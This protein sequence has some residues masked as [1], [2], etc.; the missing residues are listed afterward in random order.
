MRCIKVYTVPPADHFCD[1][2]LVLV[3]GG[4]GDTLKVAEYK[5]AM[6]LYGFLLCH[7][8]NTP[9]LCPST[10]LRASEITEV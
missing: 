7:V 3:E 8:V 10:E 5:P 6:L 1:D 4:A 2:L 9:A